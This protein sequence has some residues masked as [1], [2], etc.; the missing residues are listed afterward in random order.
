MMLDAVRL[1]LRIRISSFDEEIQDLIDAA[2][3]DLVLS[4]VEKDKIIDTDPLIKRAVI[5]FCKANFGIS[6]SDSE[7][8]TRSYELF[9]ASLSLSEDYMAGGADV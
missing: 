3:A 8:F 9:K 1:A 4:G 2:K 6:N 7:R 5:L